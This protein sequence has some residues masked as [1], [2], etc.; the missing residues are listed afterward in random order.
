MGKRKLGRPSTWVNTSFEDTKLIRV[1]KA[2][3]SQLKEIAHKLDREGLE[4][5]KLKALATLKVG[6][7]SEVYR[8]ARAVLNV[9]VKFL[10]E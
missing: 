4:R 7:Q 1:P 9:F 2:I 8:K 5:L 10:L 6:K 3:A